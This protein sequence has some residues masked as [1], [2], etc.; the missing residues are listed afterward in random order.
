MGRETGD[1]RVYACMCVCVYACMCAC[2]FV[3]LYVLLVGLGRWVRSYPY[4]VRYLGV[5]PPPLLH[6]R[7]YIIGEGHCGG[8]SCLS[9]LEPRTLLRGSCFVL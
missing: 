1:L 5:G 2:V 3:C 8:S 4:C 9:A 6:S 7:L